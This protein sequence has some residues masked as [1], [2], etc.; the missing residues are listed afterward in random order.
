MSRV[1]GG[2]MYLEHG[3]HSFSQSTAHVHDSAEKLDF[4]T[5]NGSSSY[6]MRQYSLW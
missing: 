1:G 4:G 6:I 2:F 5:V 3:M